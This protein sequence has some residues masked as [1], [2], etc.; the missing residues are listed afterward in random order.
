MK[1]LLKSIHAA[2]PEGEHGLPQIRQ[3]DIGVEGD[4]ILFVGEAPMDFIPDRTING[5]DR[6]AVPGLVNAHTHAAMTLLRHRADD[7]PFQAWLFGHIFPMEDRLQDGDCYWGALLGICE[8]LR[9]GC[10]CFNDMYMF[11]DDIVRACAESGMRAVLSQGLLGESR[12]D[13]A[14]LSRLESA[15]KDIQKYNGTEN[16]RLTFLL[17]PHAP[18]TCAPEYVRLIIERA[19]ELGVGLHTHISESRDENAQIAE[20]YGKT[21]FE[22]FESTG[23]FGLPTVAAHCVHITDND[24]AIAAKY[25]VSV[26]TNPVSNLKLSNGAAPVKRLLEAGVNVALGTDGAASNNSLNMIREL[27][28]LCLVHKGVNEDAQCVPAAQGLHIATMGGAMALGL[29]DRI[30][31]IEAGR[32]ADLAI[33]NLTY[34][35]FTP[36]SNLLAALCYGAQGNE[37]ETV[38]VDGEIL[39]ENGALTRL[40]EERIRWEAQRVAGRI[41]GA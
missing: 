31:S 2:L 34:S 16:G 4:K 9:C 28:F 11:M 35:H 23:L 15:A 24:I 3:C 37:V 1:I 38:L 26:A 41:C 14:G 22:Y 5:A 21:P 30:G 40:D 13:P 18:Y 19:G 20:K 7:L 6:L 39:L 8:M 36:R 32:K 27:G 10:T 17:A 12:E 25:G 29:G 33:L